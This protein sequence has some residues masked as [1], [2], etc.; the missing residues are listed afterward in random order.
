MSRNTGEMWGIP[1]VLIAVFWVNE[2]AEC[3]K[4]YQFAVTRNRDRSA[5]EDVLLDRMAKNRKGG[6]KTGILICEVRDEDGG[7]VQDEA[8]FG[9]AI[10]A[11]YSRVGEDA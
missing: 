7:T 5:G 6:R 11:G 3:F 10:C 2:M 9:R 1:G 4:S 8:S